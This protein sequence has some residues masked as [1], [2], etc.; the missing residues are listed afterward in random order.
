MFIERESSPP[1]ISEQQKK[2]C[3]QSTCNLQTFFVDITIIS[4]S[5]IFLFFSSLSP[6][7]YN[8]IYIAKHNTNNT[9]N[10]QANMQQF[11]N[12]KKAGPSNRSRSPSLFCI[13]V[14][15][16]SRLYV[17]NYNVRTYKYCSCSLLFC[18]CCCCCRCCADC[19]NKRRDKI[20]DTKQ[21]YACFVLCF[22]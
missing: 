9:N 12:N 3:S 18:F 19:C 10:K 21:I 7:L 11:N 16:A 13:N 17:C 14:T 5:I 15:L 20:D 2:L 1:N 6:S 4:I 8:Y 22:C